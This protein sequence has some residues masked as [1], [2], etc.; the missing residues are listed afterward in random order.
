MQTKHTSE[1]F[2]H[3]RL[4]IAVVGAL[5]ASV[6]SGQQSG[7]SIGALE[8]V[9]VTGTKR[10]ADAQDVPISISTVTEDDLSR[11][12]FNDIRALG[13]KAPGLVLSNPSGFNS[14]GGGMRGTGTNIILVTQ[15]AP[16]SFLMDEFALSHVTSQFL[17]MFDIQQVEVYRGPQGTLFGK[18]ATGGVI[19]LTSKKPVQGETSGELE[20][21]Y[22]QHDSVGNGNYGS[23]KAAINLPI[24][25]NLA[26]RTAAIYDQDDGYYRNSK[27]TATF[28]ENVPL[29]GAFGI[30][31]GTPPPPEVDT[32]TRGDG[33]QLGG[34][35]VL[36]IKSKL[37][38]E[39][40]DDFSAYLVYEYVKDESDSPP[41]VNESGEGDLISL[42]GFPGIQNAEGNT[43]V[44]ETLLTGNEIINMDDGHQVDV[45]GIY[46]NMD[47]R[48]GPGTIKS[49]SGYRE[50]SQYFPSTYTGEAFYTLFDSTRKTDRETFQQEFRFVSEFDGPFN[51]SS[52]ASYYKDELDFHS[53]FSV[54]VTSLLPVL[55]ESTGSFIDSDGFVN[56]DTRAFT[57]YQFQG[58][59]QDRDEYGLYVDGTYEFN[60]RWALSAGMRYS[61][62]TK[63]FLRGVDGGAPC[64]QFTEDRDR[65]FVD[66]DCRDTRSQYISR[67]GLD[68]SDYSGEIPFSYDQFGTR[69]DAEDTWEEMTHRLV[70]NYYPS[71]Q[72]MAY[73]SYA[74]GFLSGGFSETCATVSRCSYD[75]ETNSNIELGYKADLFDSELR[76]NAAVYYTVYEDLQRA[77]VAA[78]TAA[79][80]T[81]Q[82]ET[83]TV[84]TGESELWG[85]DIEATWVPTTNLRV[86]AALNLM[87]H[88][89]K[90]AILPDLRGTNEPID[91]EQF[92]VPFSPE[93]K[94]ML[95]V[96]YQ[97]PVSAGIVTLSGSANYQSEAETDVFNAPNSQMEAR[98]LVDLGVSFED[99]SERWMVSA[100]VANALDEEYRI[101]ALPVAG[102]F[103]FTQYGAPRSY[104]VKLRYNFGAL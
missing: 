82:Q 6:A 91:L 60:E 10:A 69:V 13:A 22:G 35:D 70:L 23:V 55:N 102:L 30:P 63:E 58:T 95:G 5:S 1:L 94:A 66:G 85:L 48:I 65:V 40:T 32:N 88:Q 31:P 71:A 103:N 28:P 42:L 25:D 104:G 33:S 64:N 2:R 100:F 81:Q 78:Y 17:N 12:Q 3:T 101:S 50:E 61:H 53:F 37:L 72:Q 49:I 74:T 52:G 9:V 97:I 38:W 79:D 96:D 20:F 24:T 76:L 59:R 27:D 84:N 83:V 51:F 68:S 34:K 19:S 46:L 67:A 77:A 39:P 44:F 93:T 54:G 73:L 15:D 62:D 36:A 56:L 87:D 47:W 99:A 11:S 7:G 16:V 26:F 89:Y 43:D 4:A 92:D 29:W 86:T 8:E 98:T 14:A 90:T 75:P 21:T 18:N 45:D 80:G 57:D 41:G